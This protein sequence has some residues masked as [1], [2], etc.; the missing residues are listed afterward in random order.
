MDF[1]NSVTRGKLE[2]AFSAGQFKNHITHIRFP[3]YKNLSENL[4]LNFTFPVTAL[5]G[6][7]GSNKT[8]ILRA[9]EACPRG[10]DLGNWWF[11]TSMDPIPPGLHPRYI[12]GF[13]IPGLA[14]VAEVRK[15]RTQRADRRSDYFETTKPADGMSPLPD[16]DKIGKEFRTKTRWMPIAKNVVYLDFRGELPAYEKFMQHPATRDSKKDLEERKEWLRDK[17]AKVRLALEGKAKKDTYYNRKVIHEIVKL[18]DEATQ[19]IGDIL[20]RQYSS[21]RMIRHDYFERPGWTVELTTNQHVYS[22]AYAGSGEFAIIVMVHQILSAPKSSL[23]LLDEPETSLHP[24]SQ[25]K[26]M[27][28]LFRRSLQDKHQIIMATHSPHIIRPLPDEAIKLLTVDPGDGK[29]HL[30]SQENSQTDAFFRLG[31]PKEGRLTVFVEDKLAAALVGMMA[32]PLG[33]AKFER[34][35]FKPYP[36]G[37]AEIKKRLVPHLAQTGRDDAVVMLDGDMLP[38]RPGPGWVVSDERN[39]IDPKSVTD[40]NIEMAFSDCFSDGSNMD[41]S[42]N[43]GNDPNIKNHTRTMQRATLEWVERNVYFLPGSSPEELVCELLNH[44]FISSKEA[45]K[46]FVAETAKELSLPD[47]RHDEISADRILETQVRALA[48]V[49]LSDGPWKTLRAVITARL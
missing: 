46:F 24:A 9:L 29:V 8:S 38:K 37:A 15:S 16:D 25:E 1:M 11:S 7:N 26:L 30:V 36:G 44:T 32:N 42:L 43:G 45:K 34:L 13:S 35:E 5:V 40:D 47:W 19:E 10:Y 20:G 33:Q 27:D 23:I 6:G 21:I 12:Y 22:E 48:R 39:L 4:Q 2:A 41:L 14:G 3:A 49:D 18:S 28:F 17:S 31:A